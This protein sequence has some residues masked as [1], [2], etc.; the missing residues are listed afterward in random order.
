MTN[1]EWKRFERNLNKLME[2]QEM[3]LGFNDKD[4]YEAGCDGNENFLNYKTNTDILKEAKYLLSTYYE[5][6][7]M[8]EELKDESPKVWRSDVAKLKRFIARLEKE[9]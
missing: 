3:A 1:E 9:A 6:G 8:N 2:L 7:H 5:D 4:E